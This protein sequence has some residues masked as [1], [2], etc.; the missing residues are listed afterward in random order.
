M[1]N[2]EFE[3]LK[4]IY[5]QLIELVS[6]AKESD[7]MDEKLDCFFKMF[8]IVRACLE[9]SPYTHFYTQI[10][11]DIIVKTYNTKVF[12]S[13]LL[14]KSDIGCF[15]ENLEY[16]PNE[17]FEE[18]EEN[19]YNINLIMHEFTQKIGKISKKTHKKYMDFFETI[20]DLL[21]KDFMEKKSDLKERLELIS[22]Y[23]QNSTVKNL[24]T[25]ERLYLYEAKR[26]FD[27]HY[28]NTNP[29]HALFLDTKFKTK[30]ICNAELS[31][32][33]KR[34]DVENVVNLIKE[35]HIM[36]EEVYEL[37]NAEEQIRFE[38]F[39][40]I[41]NNFTINKCKNCGKLFI[42]ITTS[43]NKNQK[44]RNDQKYCNNLYLDTGKTCREIG[45]LN[46]RKEKV[47]NSLILKE[48]SREYKRI[49]GL[50][51]NHT[52]T[53]KEKQFKG[54]SNKARALRNRYSDE[55]IDEF[56]IELKKLSNIYWHSPR[57]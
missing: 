8:Q 21:I 20:R 10:L 26:V 36:A 1:D 34:L 13:D 9:F 55:Q 19:E 38:L 56:K 7:I 31:L 12:R 5:S 43:K 41:Q 40:I 46:K 24:S 11:I 53:F 28:V 2:K 48:Y 14:F 50:H 49:Y 29:A 23:S 25:N 4:N 33:E 44:G 32:Q 6:T 3:R 54:W 30:Y 35:K 45:A 16:S 52:K 39:K 18:L 22:K 15:I 42:P 17:F 51:Y 47:Q 57:N 37:A 27:I